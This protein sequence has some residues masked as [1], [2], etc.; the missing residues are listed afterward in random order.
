MV[1]MRKVELEFDGLDLSF[2][3][4]DNNE[5]QGVGI[6]SKRT[7]HEFV[8]HTQKVD[9]AE[10]LFATAVNVQKKVLE[11]GITLDNDQKLAVRTVVKNM[12]QLNEDLA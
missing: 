4:I 7:G 5:D 12:L 10:R 1:K 3:P 2:Y 9:Q 11:M 8:P 6:F